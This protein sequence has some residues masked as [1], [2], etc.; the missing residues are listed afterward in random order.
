MN[1]EIIV[2]TS[3]TWDLFHVGHLNILEKSARL[4][5]KLIVG[6]STDELIMEYK[7]IPPVIPFEQRF[8]II[9]SIKWVHK[10]VKQE[11]LTEIKQL[12]ELNVDIVT[13]GDDWKNKYLE[14]LEWIK[15]QPDKKVVY[16][17]YTGQISTTSIKRNIIKN[18]YEIIFSELSREVAHMEEWK[19]KQAVKKKNNL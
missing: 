17:P 16:I 9:E 19:R 11:V 18:S 6:V 3:G 13:I 1:K 14:G 12:K 15:K 4:G 2:Y 8:K 7:G 5:D 10:A